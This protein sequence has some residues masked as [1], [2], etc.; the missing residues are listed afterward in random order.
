MMKDNGRSGGNGTGL[1]H[2]SLKELQALKADVERAIAAKRAVEPKVR[3]Q[4]LELAQAA[5]FDARDL[6]GPKPRAKRLQMRAARGP[7]KK[8]HKGAKPAKYRDP[9]DPKRTWSGYGHAPK[10]FRTATR[11]QPREAL[12]IG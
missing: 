9:A 10:W 2:R 4:L 3:Q 5:G 1:E 11:T 12:L 7:A 8:A 6:L